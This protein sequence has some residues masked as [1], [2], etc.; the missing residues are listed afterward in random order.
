LSSKSARAEKASAESFFGTGHS[1]IC[2]YCE[3]VI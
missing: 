1:E 2:K 3:V